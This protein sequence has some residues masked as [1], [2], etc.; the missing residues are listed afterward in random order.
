VSVFYI[1][2]HTLPRAKKN[3]RWKRTILATTPQEKRKGG[4]F[5]YKQE[6]NTHTHTQRNKEKN[7]EE[8]RHSEQQLL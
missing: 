1:T 3:D 8:R 6:E 5:K 4:P 2:I 7:E